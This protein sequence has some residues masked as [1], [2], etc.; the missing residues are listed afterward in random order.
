MGYTGV[1]N[2]TAYRNKALFKVSRNGNEEKN[3]QSDMLV[4]GPQGP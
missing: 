2:F 3:L 4:P 1:L